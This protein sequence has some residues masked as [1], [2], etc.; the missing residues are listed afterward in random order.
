VTQ[1]LAGL[2]V[3]LLIV[4]SAVAVLA[5]KRVLAQLAGD[6]AQ[7]IRFF[8]STIAGAWALAV[9][10]TS[11]TL[12]PFDELH[13][14][15]VGWSWSTGGYLGLTPSAGAVLTGLLAVVWVGLALNSTAAARE[16]IRAGKPSPMHPEH[17]LLLPRTPQER[18]LIGG[19]AVTAGITEEI[20]YRGFLIGAS[21]TV[22][23]APPLLAAA[24]SLVL[25][26]GGHAYQGRRGMRGITLLGLMF[27]MLFVLSGSILPGIV[28][29][30]VQDLLSLLTIPRAQTTTAKIPAQ[31][32]P[33]ASA[34]VEPGTSNEL[35]AA[36]QPS[37]SNQPTATD[38]ASTANKGAA[39]QNAGN[40]G[41]ANAGAPD[42]PA[43]PA[44]D[45]DDKLALAPAL[46]PP[47]I[48]P[49]SPE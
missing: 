40:K 9:L 46:T 36:N 42:S 11:F 33:G 26:V 44:A 32:E 29:H 41:A 49:P 16:Q 39:D 4:N 38:E 12:A 48:R 30:V 28:V 22:L 43:M 19:L 21:V 27:T 35:S 20:V 8:R 7:R 3:G 2:L 31:P 24:L 37:A 34:A 1:A 14:A 23:G 10:V 45:R 18:R 6:P 25:F 17:A 15:D 47:T 13:P 5:R